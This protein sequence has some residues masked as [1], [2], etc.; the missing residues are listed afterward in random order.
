MFAT[1]ADH[2]LDLGE[3]ARAR[4]LLEEAL[5]LGKNTTKGI[6]G[7]GFNVGIVAVTLTRLDLPAGLKLLDELARDIRQN[8]TRD[9]S[10]VFDRFH[11]QIAYKL[12][13]QSPA[14]AEQ[15]LERIPLIAAGD[16]YV[17]AV[18][19]KMAPKD[20][21]RARRIAE[22]RIS[23][24]SLG[25]KGYALGLMAQALAGSDK[26]AAIRLLDEAYVSL[27]E[28]AESGQRP[29]RPEIVEVAAGLL[30]IVEQVDPDRLSEFLG[31]TLALRPARGDQTI[32]SEAGVA[33][34]TAALAT[35]VARYDRKLA[36]HLLEPELQKTGTYQGLFGSDYVTWRI[37]AALA[38]VDP[39]RAVERVEA[40]PD[41]PGNGTDPDSTKNQ[42]RIHIANLLAHHGADRWRYVYESF[43]YLWTP[44]SRRL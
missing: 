38:L 17:V 42:A 12:A 40:L 44:D 43:V 19:A 13:A 3:N 6:K 35:L 10:Y 29:I 34:T 33:G 26:P 8:E 7:G 21:S 28:L 41:D 30:P 18:C 31:R 22:T 32:L 37:L 20:L 2:W 16:P 5:A 11:G 27:E 1:I 4:A 23:A 25:L 24:D 36:A 15:V 9:R 39:R 14:D